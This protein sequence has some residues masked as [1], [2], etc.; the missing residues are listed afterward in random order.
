M[1]SETSIE[2]S[3]RDLRKLIIPLVIEQL[4]AITVG[5]AD[6]MMVAR[7]G[8]AAV[9]A[10]S[11]VDSVNVLLVSAFAALATGGAVVAGQYLGRREMEK[12]NHSAQ[13]LF[14]F[15]GECALVITALLYLLKGFILHVV[16]GAIEADVAA[17]ADTYFMIVESSTFFL[18]IYNAGAALFRV[19]GN[20]NISMVVSLLMNGINVA[21]NAILI[22]GFHMGVAGVAI[23]TLV[24][25]IVAAVLMV[26]L[27]CRKD[28]VLH[29]SRP[30]SFRHER[31]MI[32]NILYIGVPNGIEGSMFQLGKLMLLTAVTVFGTAS[33]AANAIGN[34]VGTFQC[35]APQSI[36][37]GMVTVVSRCVG[38]GDMK[39]ARFYTRKLMKW[40]YASMLLTNLL[41]FAL[42]P[43]IL[44]IYGLSEE[45]NAYA[46]VILFSHGGV[47]ILLWPL[48]F[49]LPQTL[50][51]AGDTRFTMTVS[52]LSMWI[53][54][55]I[56]GVWFARGLGFGVLGIWFAMYIDWVCRTVFF[57]ARYRGRR[58]EL[59]GLKA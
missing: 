24:S 15:M 41:I 9:S 39:K 17:Y 18:A 1:Q 32:R 51:A 13:Q 43:V 53:F 8:E 56:F 19:M 3:N 6:S 33:V 30:F 31:S 38:A 4:L 11:L 22:F 42:M 23:P 12:A 50:R 28:L 10:V 35:M 52:S 16:F 36:G 20:S 57:V 26:V 44:W 37:L 45:T 54:R 55:V 29:L 59:K 25:K 40:G 58:W 7:V 5:L 14:L 48:A 49:Q 34:I 21:G 47:G 27:L 2:F 46:R